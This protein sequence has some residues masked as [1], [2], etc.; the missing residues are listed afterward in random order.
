LATSEELEAVQKLGGGKADSGLSL[1]APVGDVTENGSMATWRT[2]T[3]N[4]LSLLRIL[5]M[6]CG[7]TPEELAVTA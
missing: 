1:S 5:S 7:A 2:H 3:E 6:A 4:K